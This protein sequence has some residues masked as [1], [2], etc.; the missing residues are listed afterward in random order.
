M[1]SST[2]FQDVISGAAAT[3]AATAIL[4]LFAWLAGPLR[5]WFE[6]R[7]M[8]RLVGGNRRFHFTFNPETRAGKDLTFQPDG[9]IGEGRNNQEHSWRI[10]RGRV[11]IFA[12]DGKVYSRFRHDRG[13]GL[14]RHTNDPDL[15]S[16]HG[17]YLQPKFVKVISDAA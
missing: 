6:N 13:S 16:I 7:A 5:W 3:I 12:A 1:T 17:Q 11:E 15:R 10:R 14:L 4:A 8:R 9:S 2:I